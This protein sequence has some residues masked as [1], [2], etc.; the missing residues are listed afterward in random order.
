MVSGRDELFRNCNRRRTVWRRSIDTRGD[1]RLWRGLW[2][3]SL[4]NEMAMTGL[5]TPGNENRSGLGV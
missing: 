1:A 4:R 5:A 3:I 2:N